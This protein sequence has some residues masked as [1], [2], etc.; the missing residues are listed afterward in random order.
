[1]AQCRS[2]ARI[3]TLVAAPL[4]NLVVKLAHPTKAVTA[5]SFSAV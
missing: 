2:H 4:Q 3:G 5:N 1:M